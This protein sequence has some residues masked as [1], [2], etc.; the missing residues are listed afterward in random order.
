[1]SIK[2]K[3]L[4]LNIASL[5][6][7]WHNLDYFN[8]G[9]FMK[10]VL[11]IF[12]LL[13]TSNAFS[14]ARWNEA[15]NP[16]LMEFDFERNFSALPQEGKLKVMPWSDDYWASING[17]ISYRWAVPG[18]DE[19]SK[20]AYPLVDPN[21][22]SERDLFLLSPS[23][24]YDL[25]VGDT[26][27][28][29]TN[30][31]RKRT[32]ALAMIKGTPEFD[33][34]VDIKDW[35]GICHAWAP[36]TLGYKNPRPVYMTGK[37]GHLIPFGAS[38]IKALLSLNVDLSD[39]DTKTKFLGSRCNLDFQ[40][41]IKK[42]RNGEISE[43]ELNTKINT[44]E[45]N[46]TNAGTFHIVLTNQ[47]AKRN[48]GF[49]IDRTRDLEVWNQPV[50]GYKSQILGT[51]DGASPGAA[52]GTVKE[53]LVETTLLFIAEIHPTFS[54]RFNERAIQSILYRYRLELNKVGEIIGGEWL[55]YERPDFIYKQTVPGFTGFF[56][57]LE[58]IYKRS[59]G[60]I[61]PA[62]STAAI[63]KV[64]KV[65][66][67]EF[68]KKKF[69]KGIKFQ[70]IKKRAMNAAIKEGRLNVINRRFI[71]ESKILVEKRKELNRALISAVQSRDRDAIIKYV[72]LG[73]NVNATEGLVGP[74]FMINA[75]MH[76]QNLDII[77]L[78]IQKKATLETVLVKA[79]AL[80]DMDIF[81]TLIR[82]GADVNYY[83]KEVLSNSLLK[84]A[85]LGKVEMVKIL[86][87]NGAK[88]TINATGINGRNA[89]MLAIRGLGDGTD[90]ERM[91]I[92]EL[93]ISS[94]IDTSAKDEK[95]KDAAFHA[96]E[97]GN[98]Y[99]RRILKLLGA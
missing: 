98:S 58:E 75:I 85:H 30:F 63:K 91:E 11:F 22:L 8:Q 19:V 51:Q 50:Y 74:E 66:S 13:L 97:K 47:I 46:D 73:A 59:T 70:I 4:H 12:T 95:G 34:T 84:A 57:P 18:E 23:E 36:A 21:K 1:M 82:A 88:A 89:L 28:S 76:K 67:R 32:K 41:L 27:F 54:G 69:L 86:L 49:I 55:S 96:N 43:A 64:K 7:L 2:I 92:V 90:R 87:A 77:K 93:L 72:N 5:I 65:S 42:F 15:N 26:K 33:P 52:P 38:D 31:E 71:K 3:N 25:F 6:A 81:N 24:K 99:K 29:L 14:M 78:F 62:V 35:E 94:G 39:K 48:E 40:P 17:G 80:G 10:N 45:C 83:S 44:D 68:L 56:K 60:A 61:N 20:I 37:L 79:V 9:I 16:E 53:V